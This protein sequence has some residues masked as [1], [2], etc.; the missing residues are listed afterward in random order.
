MTLRRLRDPLNIR[1]ATIAHRF[2]WHASRSTQEWDLRLYP[3]LT[4]SNLGAPSPGSVAL[5][6]RGGNVDGHCR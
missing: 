3:D 1:P 2:A 5:A 6:C 4:D